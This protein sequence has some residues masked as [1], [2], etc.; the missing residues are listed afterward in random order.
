MHPFNYYIT[1]LQFRLSVTIP[2][3]SANA[4]G[5]GAFLGLYANLRYQLLCGLDQYM[6]KRFDVLG[7]AIFFSTAAR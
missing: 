3:V 4:L 5:Y 2:S 7:V 1:T 6:V